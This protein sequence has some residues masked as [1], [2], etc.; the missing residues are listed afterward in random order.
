MGKGPEQTFLQGRYTDG[1]QALETVLNITANQNYHLTPVRTAIINKSTNNKCWKGCGEKGTLL[2]CWWEC[3]LVQPLWRTV[4][5]YLRKLY[6]INPR[7]NTL[8]HILI[9]LTK[10]KDKEKILKAAREN[11]QII[12]KGTSRGLLADFSA[13]TLWAWREWPDILNMMKG[14]NPK[15][16]LPSKAL[17]HVFFFYH[18]F[19]YIYFSIV[20]HGDPVTHTCV[21]SFFSHYH[22]PS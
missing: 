18:L 2:H 6:K 11:K 19:I 13:E 10:I 17:V 22:A 3:K 9:K 8:R 12:Y 15:I 4:W 21:H 14:K 7:R 1:Q 5:R 16:T 20:L